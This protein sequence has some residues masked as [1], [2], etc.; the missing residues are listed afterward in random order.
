MSRIRLGHPSCS[1]FQC[2]SLLKLT[3]PPVTEDGLHTTG[4]LCE[5]GGR[6]RFALSL[7]RHTLPPL[8]QPASC[9]GRMLWWLVSRVRVC[10][11]WLGLPAT[12]PPIDIQIL[13]E[14]VPPATAIH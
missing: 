10:D 3:R 14:G 5:D 6:F 12:Q 11:D 8:A 7:F 4:P 9:P 1:Y 13:N 2:V